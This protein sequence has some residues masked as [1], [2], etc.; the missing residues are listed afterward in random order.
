[1]FTLLAAWES[2]LHK[3]KLLRGRLV[4]RAERVLLLKSCAHVR[5]LLRSRKPGQLETLTGVHL[6]GVEPVADLVQS[7]SVAR[8]TADASV[9]PQPEREQA[10]S[11]HMKCQPSCAR[12]DRDPRRKLSPPASSSD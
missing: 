10:L 9:L 6:R 11:I 1:M 4:G 2:L 5:Y 8:E 7:A 3:L 12:S